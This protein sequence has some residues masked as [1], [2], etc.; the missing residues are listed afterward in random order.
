MT[1]IN[2]NLAIDGEGQGHVS[3]V[4][5]GALVSIP[6][7][8][9]NFKRIVHALAEGNDPVEFLDVLKAAEQ[10]SDRVTVSEDTVYFDGEPL[11]NGITRTILRYRADGRDADNI[12]RFLE[13]VQTN[14]SRHSREQLWGWVENA[15]LHIDADGRIV[16]W[17]SVEVV[18]DWDD[19]SSEWA[20]GADR[21]GEFETYRSHSSG[22]AWVNGEEHEGKIPYAVGD[23]VTI[24]RE[25]VE[26][27]PAV[28]CSHGLHIGSYEY[29]S[30]F[31]SYNSK[32]LEVAV[33]P[34]DVV[35]VPHDSRQQKIRCAQFEVLAVQDLPTPDL[36]HY[37]PEA[38]WD[39]EAAEDEIIE[40]LQPDEVQQT[41]LGRLF[42]RRA[43]V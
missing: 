16:A 31:S 32:L 22:T 38:T 23:V 42:G 29:A 27:N 33:A 4:S 43:K 34:E 9:P 5:N 18:K 37:E 19:T 20:D 25:L 12:V 6:S 40:D 21:P 3:F 30:T 17:K 11:N 13:R 2:F 24:P 41:F 36:S 26:D 8:H 10:I 7:D 14:P 1:T 15:D 28:A 35:S 39:G